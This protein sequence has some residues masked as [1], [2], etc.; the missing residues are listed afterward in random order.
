MEYV[1]LRKG[2][3]AQTILQKNDLPKVSEN[4]S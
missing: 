1:I 4:K 3:K 2:A